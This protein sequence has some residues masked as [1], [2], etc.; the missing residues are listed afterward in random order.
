MKFFTVFAASLV[1]SATAD[2]AVRFNE[3]VVLEGHT[4]KNDF[5]SPLPHE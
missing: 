2:D 1:A 4:V 3:L 5:T